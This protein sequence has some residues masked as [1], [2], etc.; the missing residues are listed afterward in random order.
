MN[1]RKFIVGAAA[2]FATCATYAFPETE[3]DA[4]LKTLYGRLSFEDYALVA[5]AARTLE[6]NSNGKDLENCY[7]KLRM[8]WLPLRGIMPSPAN[9]CGVW[10]W[11]SAFHAI[12]VSK[13]SQGYARDQIRLFLDLFQLADGMYCDCIREGEDSIAHTSLSRK[14]LPGFQMV[15]VCT[16]PPVFAWGAWVY[17][18][19]YRD[20][21]LLAEVYPSLVRNVGWWKAKRHH[22]GTG[23]FH[24]DGNADNDADRKVAA[25]WESGMDDSPRWD[26][27]AWNFCAIDL[28][29]YMVST[30]RALA[31]FAT[32]L[33]KADEAKAWRAE[34]DA[35][36]ARIE[37]ALW[38]EKDGCYY[39]WNFRT[40]SFSRILS[41][42]SFA[43]LFFGIASKEHAAA[44]AHQAPRMSPGWPTV[45]YDDPKYDPMGY[46]RGR[47]W[48]N[49][50]YMALKGLKAYGYA[51]L[52]ETGRRELLG[53]ARNDP[54][55]LY[56]NYNSK[57]G[58]PAG[59]PHFGWTST[60]VLSFVLDWN[61]KPVDERP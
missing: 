37:K 52:A 11:D 50:A 40:K 1:R 34:A 45:S 32:R 55:V 25:G 38:D 41:P 14:P 5:R 3:C 57:T 61:L 47:T 26:G 58:E 44:M 56:E 54:G 15:T 12:G 23:L 2:V 51:D 49:V 27:D 6:A 33:G 16:K 22:P 8:P 46:W 48:F 9:F 24:Y 20:G 21:K 30:Y 36:A 18:R 43:P 53:W 59:A 31:D 13:W 17:D 28:N 29:C 60:F 42:A 10:N 19:K 35:L 7:T 39:D 4:W